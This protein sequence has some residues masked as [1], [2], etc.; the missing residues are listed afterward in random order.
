M[1][2]LLLLV[3]LLWSA[4]AYAQD[5]PAIVAGR[6]GLDAHSRGDWKA[7]EE[8]F[9]RANELMHSPVFVVYLA[10]CK[11]RLDK[12]LEARALYDSVITETLPEDAPPP[13]QEAKR[14]AER[15]RDALVGATPALLIRL[16]DTPEG[17]QVTLDDR[18]VAVGE[19]VAVDPGTHR[20]VLVV[21]GEGVSERQI[22]SARGGGETLI[23]LHMP[24]EDDEAEPSGSI[25][26]GVVLVGVG[27][28]GLLLGTVFGALALDREAEVKDSCNGTQCPSSS[29]PIKEEAE[30]FSHVSTAGFVI[31]GVAAAVGVVLLI[32]RPGGGDAEVALGPAQASLRIRF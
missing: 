31:G 21:N 7:C 22:V 1:R 30:T 15:E 5:N 25:A 23:E 9:A 17:A 11:N 27:G 12:L 3:L 16:V 26:P 4:A 28:I 18:A 19:P 20:V 14:D 2:P 24:S 29:E 10:R 32:W 13:W 6:E 8:H